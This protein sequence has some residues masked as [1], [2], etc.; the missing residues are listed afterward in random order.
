MLV[1]IVAL[2][3][4][5]RVRRV[6]WKATQSREFRRQYSTTG[7]AALKY[8][9]ASA[10]VAQWIHAGRLAAVRAGPW[11]FVDRRELAAFLKTLPK[12]GTKTRAKILGHRRLMV[13]RRLG[14]RSP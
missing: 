5:R 14:T 2:P 7:E 1:P 3:P 8:R 6:P 11:W 9:M 13:L 4:A 10:T 12:P